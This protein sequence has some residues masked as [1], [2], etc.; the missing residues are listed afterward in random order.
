VPLLAARGA[1]VVIACHALLKDLLQT[2]AGV[3]AV[4]TTEETPPAFDYHIPIMSLPRAFGTVLATIPLQVPYLH[5]VPTAT[6]AWRSRLASHGTRLKVGLAWAGNPKHRRDRARSCAIERLAPLLEST[7]CAFYSLQKAAAAAEVVKLD[8]SGERVCDYSGELETFADTAAFIGALDL[9]ISVDTAVAHLA[10]ALGKPVWILLPFAADWRWLQER[11][12]SPWY[13]SA[14]L[15]R[16]PRAGDWDS[17]IESV[18]AALADP[19]APSRASPGNEPSS[20]SS[21]A[22]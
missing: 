19:R 8:A 9:V 16:Q 6:D 2:V 18:A 20:P 7:P 12:D 13:P 10:G 14:R 5:A 21:T 1:H 3:G 15:F 11:E 17:V 4:I 22:G